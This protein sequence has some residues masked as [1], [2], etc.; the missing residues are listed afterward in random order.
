[1]KALISPNEIYN[2]EWVV[3]WDKQGTREATGGLIDNWVPTFNQVLEVTRVADVVEV[4]FD[5]AEP[6]FWV[7]CAS[8]CTRDNCYYKDSV[9]VKKPVSVEYP[10]E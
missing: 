4:A 9:V 10:A 6:L 7:D 2:Y 5:V 8:D 1:M 3:S